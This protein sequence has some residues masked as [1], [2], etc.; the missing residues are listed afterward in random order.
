MSVAELL[1][2]GKL[3][4]GLAIVLLLNLEVEDHAGLFMILR[5]NSEAGLAQLQG[6]CHV[7]PRD[8]VHPYEHGAPSNMRRQMRQ[9]WRQLLFLLQFYTYYTA[10]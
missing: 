2:A 7:D 8:D 6:V 10:W 4:F 9:L 5:V 1:P 3:E